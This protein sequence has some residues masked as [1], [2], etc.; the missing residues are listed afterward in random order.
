MLVNCTTPPCAVSCARLSQVKVC[1]TVYVARHPRIAG[2]SSGCYL[3]QCQLNLDNVFWDAT[4]LHTVY[5]LSE[6]SVH[7]GTVSMIHSISGG[8]SV[9]PGYV[10]DTAD[11]PQVDVV[12]PSIHAPKPYCRVLAKQ[13]L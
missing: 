11:A 9:L 8:Y 12:E 2:G 6:Q 10:Q 3:P 5:A 1:I 7:T 13:V 4:I